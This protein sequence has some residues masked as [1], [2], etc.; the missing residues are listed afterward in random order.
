[1]DYTLIYTW[2]FQLHS[3]WKIVTLTVLFYTI[4]RSKE[5][6]KDGE[7]ILK[8][9]NFKPLDLRITLFGLIFSNI[10]LSIK[11][12][13]YLL[14]PKLKLWSNGFNEIFNNNDVFYLL[15]ES[16]FYNIFAVLLINIG[17]SLFKKATSN[18]KRFSRVILFYTIGLLFL[19]L[20]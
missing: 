9:L 1:M 7:L 6:I 19:F 11:L 5:T 14:S 4:F 15:I 20:G 18:K 17:W 13:L 10:Y 8:N 16:P 12:I 3:F 2:V